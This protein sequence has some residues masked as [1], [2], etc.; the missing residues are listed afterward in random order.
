MKKYTTNRINSIGKKNDTP[1][2]GAFCKKICNFIIVSYYSVTSIWPVTL[3]FVVGGVVF[4]VNV[5]VLF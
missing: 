3:S 2:L 4:A 5:T 1:L